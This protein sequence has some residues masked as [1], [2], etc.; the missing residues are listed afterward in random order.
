MTACI[1]F[2]LILIRAVIETLQT[3]NARQQNIPRKDIERITADQIDAIVGY[4][5]DFE[6]PDF[7]G[8]EWHIPEQKMSGVQLPYFQLSV[9]DKFRQQLNMSG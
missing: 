5:R 4:L 3:R 2:W 1:I 7:K 8:G 9:S 6:R